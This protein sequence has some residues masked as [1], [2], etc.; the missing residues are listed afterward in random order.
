[1]STNNTITID[2]VTFV[3]DTKTVSEAI[4]ALGLS[5]SRPLLGLRRQG[6]TRTRTS[7]GQ[8]TSLSHTT[9][10]MSAEYLLL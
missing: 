10:T 5:A 8:G 1:M 9:I 3:W 7:S 6:I 4:H 2:Y